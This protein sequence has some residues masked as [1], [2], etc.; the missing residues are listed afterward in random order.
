LWL[1]SYGHAFLISLVKKS[2]TNEI[3]LNVQTSQWLN[4]LLFSLLLL[5]RSVTAL[6]L[7]GKKIHAFLMFLENFRRMTVE[8]KYNGFSILA[9]AAEIRAQFL[10][11]MEN[12][13]RMF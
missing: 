11:F 12:Y 6:D 3:H 4:F 10:S 1:W 7:H 13:G 9:A 8:K 5:F 2:T